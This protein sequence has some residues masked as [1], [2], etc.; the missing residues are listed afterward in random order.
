MTEKTIP[1]FEGTIP[2]E[3]EKI[4]DFVARWA[5]VMTPDQVVFCDGSYLDALHSQVFVAFFCGNAF[6]DRYTCA[7]KGH[8]PPSLRIISSRASVQKPQPAATFIT[9]CTQ[10]SVMSS[11]AHC[12]ASV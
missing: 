2:T 8:L 12:S 11:C 4:I 7:P 5:E 10:R 1:G 3:N 9:N 6:R